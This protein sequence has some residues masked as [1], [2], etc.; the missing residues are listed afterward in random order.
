MIG[1][2]TCYLKEQNGLSGLHPVCA[3]ILRL[4]DILHMVPAEEIFIPLVKFYGFYRFADP[5]YC[6]CKK[7]HCM[8]WSCWQ[9]VT[10]GCS[11]NNYTLS[12]CLYMHLLGRR[13]PAAD[14][15]S[16]LNHEPAISDQA[17]NTINQWC[18]NQARTSSQTVMYSLL[19]HIMIDMNGF[20][21]VIW[22]HEWTIHNW[23]N[24]GS[25][26]FDAWWQANLI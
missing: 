10:L 23:Y 13:S 6:G 12:L 15:L 16:A 14:P 1:N 11:I 19:W 7:L 22:L 9:L 2:V 20:L 24:W 3:K 17:N 8:S 18:E 25:L 4:P 5:K 21:L 26:K